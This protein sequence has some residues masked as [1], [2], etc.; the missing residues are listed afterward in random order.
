MRHDKVSWKSFWT[1]GELVAEWIAL[2]RQS[3]GDCP[4]FSA[5]TIRRMVGE[6]N[7]TVPLSAARYYLCVLSRKRLPWARFAALVVT[8]AANKNSGPIHRWIGPPIFDQ[9]FLLNTQ[10]K[11]TL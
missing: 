10:K 1:G 6:K 5:G 8:C 11:I 2:D 7:G 4:D 9:T 3:V